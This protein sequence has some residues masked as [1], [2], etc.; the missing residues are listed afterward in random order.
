M[1]SFLFIVADISDDIG[2]ICL[3]KHKSRRGRIG[4]NLYRSGSLVSGALH[5]ADKCA[6]NRSVH[7]QVQ[8]RLAI[9]AVQEPGSIVEPEVRLFVRPYF[10]LDYASN[11]SA[12]GRRRRS[13]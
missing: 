10:P 4:E 5:N 7:D 2:Y 9:K 13:P 3:D 6:L 12:N 8:R 11:P 1:T